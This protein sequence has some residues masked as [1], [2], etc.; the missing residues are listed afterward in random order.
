MTASESS[1]LTNSRQLCDI[2]PECAK[3]LILRSRVFSSEPSELT[4]LR[5]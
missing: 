2:R 3:M 1:S 5:D 4:V